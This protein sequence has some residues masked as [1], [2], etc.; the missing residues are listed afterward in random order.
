MEKLAA[1]LYPVLDFQDTKHLIPLLTSD[2]AWNYTKT[3]LGSTILGIE[4][5]DT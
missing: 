1:S 5:V 3:V 4:H 2:N